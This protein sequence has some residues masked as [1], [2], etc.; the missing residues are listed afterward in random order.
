[1]GVIAKF[2]ADA[3]LYEILGVEEDASG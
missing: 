3:R 1:M 2:R